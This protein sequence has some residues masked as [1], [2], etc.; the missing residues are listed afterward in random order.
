LIYEFDNFSLDIDRRELRRGTSVVAIEPQVFDL[1]YCLV[2]N[3]D[4]V[5]SRD[6]LIEAVWNGR[7][8]SDSTLSSRL[9]AVRH[10]IDDSGSEQRLIR[11]VTRKGFRFIGEVRQRVHREDAVEPHKQ[12][13]RDH[14]GPA[15]APLPSGRISLAVLPFSD[16]SRSVDGFVQ[17]LTDDIATE[18]SHFCWLSVIGHRPPLLHQRWTVDIAHPRREVGIHYVVEGAVRTDGR[19]VRVTARLV[20]TMTGALLWAGRFDEWNEDIF[21]LQDRIT[22]RVVGAIGP[23]LE[24]FEIAR[25]KRTPAEKQDSVQCYLD[26]MGSIYQWNRAGIDDALSLFRRAFAIDPEFAAAYGMAAYC[27]VQRKS[28]G[29]IAHRGQETA[30]CAWLAR[31]AAEFAADD[32]AALAKAAHAIASVARDVDTGAV[33]VDRA[34]Q[35]NPKLAAGWYVSGWI[36]LFLGEPEPAIEHLSYALRLGPSDPLLFKTQG[37]LAYAHFLT[38]RYDDAA[39][40]ASAALRVR[41]DYLTAVRA[42]AA[43]HALAGRLDVAR[44]LMAHMR[45]R[46]SAL[47]MSNLEDLIPFYRSADFARWSEG[48]HR[49]GLPD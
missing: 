49:A 28:Y 48:L 35:L 12:R 21:A 33:F 36:R 47:R 19:R 37:A 44:S 32:A 22:A 38:G 8:I 26:G 2:R 42:A 20:E 29:W 6:D 45:S 40:L 41:P 17:G 7:L 18:L 11:T 43:S 25:A 46:D 5:V 30:E 34:L 23:K 39:L 15:W 24:R 31:C 3:R 16:L 1:L 4:R 27:Y 14:R 13:L 9:T 10:A